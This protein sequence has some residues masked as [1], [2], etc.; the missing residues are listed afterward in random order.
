M[1]SSLARQALFAEFASVAEA[2]AHGHRLMLL[3]L[4]A[5]G[6]RDVQHLAALT[7]LPG[8]SVSQHLQ[9]LKAGGLVTARRD[10]RRQ[11][12]RLS[13]ERVAD[14]VSDL[15]RVAETSLA[16][17]GKTV[18]DA[19]RATDELPAISAADL[20]RLLDAGKV[21]IVDV[22]PEEEY[23]AAHIPG[24]RNLPFEAIETASRALPRDRSIIVYCRGPY[25]DLTFEA[26]R[27]LRRLGYDVRRLEGGVPEWRRAGL[28]LES[29][30][31]AAPTP[32]PAG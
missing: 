4:L 32:S 21:E 6:E 25:C 27:R 18:D 9:R 13:N 7:G 22:R 17:I 12:Y 26:V 29:G 23:A 14:L 16:S 15:E 3:E 19:R 11:I 8:A 10:G 2:L 28:P 5:Q 24:A 31:A 1:S 30:S 20:A